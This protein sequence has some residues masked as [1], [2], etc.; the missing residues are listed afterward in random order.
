M[1]AAGDL[2]MGAWPEGTVRYHFA[3]HRPCI[4]LYHGRFI[5]A[6]QNRGLIPRLFF[7]LFFCHKL[8]ENLLKTC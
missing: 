6:N 8:A 3:A 5:E 7:L 2:P 4:G 1:Q